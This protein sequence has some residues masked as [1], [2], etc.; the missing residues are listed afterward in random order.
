MGKLIVKNIIICVLVQMVFLPK[1][2]WAKSHLSLANQPI[3]CLSPKSQIGKNNIRILFEDNMLKQREEAIERAMN[4][5]FKRDSKGQRI[6]YMAKKTENEIKREAKIQ[7]DQASWAMTMQFNYNLSSY[8]RPEHNLSANI[9]GYVVDTNGNYPYLERVLKSGN[10][11]KALDLIVILEENGFEIPYID[12][13]PFAQGRDL[14]TFVTKKLRNLARKYAN[15]EIRIVQVVNR[16]TLEIL[17]KIVVEKGRGIKEAEE[18]VSLY[19]D[20]YRNGQVDTSAL[21]RIIGRDIVL[22]KED[23]L[24]REKFITSLVNALEAIR[25]KG[26]RI[27]EQDGINEI[28]LM[29]IMKKAGYKSVRIEFCKN[30]EA[31]KLYNEHLKEIRICAGIRDLQHVIRKNNLENP[32]SL[33][34]TKDALRLPGS[35]YLRPVPTQNVIVFIN[36][37]I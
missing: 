3:G 18:H 4:E 28:P 32:D 37:A 19:K 34:N 24:I 30:E 5:A 15:G 17:H 9:T 36:Q 12:V 14:F 2:I 25:V 31:S 11:P 26:V 23:Y 27:N 13:Y 8:S 7:K 35:K 20:L 21:I 33:S 6:K 10:N 29:K 16:P 22:G 1:I